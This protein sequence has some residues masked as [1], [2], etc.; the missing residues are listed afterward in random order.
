MRVLVVD[1]DDATRTGLCELLAGAG[2]EP[3]AAATFEDAVRILSGSDISLLLTD[4]YLPD[5]NGLQL[6]SRSVRGVPTIVLTGFD[7]RELE[8][9]VTR[10]GALFMVKPVGPGRLLDEV[11]RVI[12][13]ASSA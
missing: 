9:E 6:M 4:L 3:V 5:G 11:E 12:A 1:D 2:Y 8:S 10:Q 13:E 7:N